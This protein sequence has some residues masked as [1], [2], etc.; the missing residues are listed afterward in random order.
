MHCPFCAS[1]DLRVIET[2]HETVRNGIRRRRACNACGRRFSTYERPL[3]TTPLIRKRDGRREEF[4][5]EKLLRGLRIACAKRPVAEGELQ[6]LVNE[7]ETRLQETGKPEVE[8]RIIGDM[9]IERLKQLDQVAYI[10]FA[11]VYLGLRDL[12]SVRTEIDR[13]LENA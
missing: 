4:D 11:I 5:R 9:A 6:R 10:R 3:L 8:G 12:Q 13:L 7:V 1:P 2:N